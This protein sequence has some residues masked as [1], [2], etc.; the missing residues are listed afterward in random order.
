MAE[1]SKYSTLLRSAKAFASSKLIL[2]LFSSLVP[3]VDLV[4]DEHHD[5][6]RTGVDRDLFEPA[7]DVVEAL[8]AGHVEDDQGSDGA[9]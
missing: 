7:V 3:A 5:D 4:S 8:A 6:V 2:R 9:Y 1:V